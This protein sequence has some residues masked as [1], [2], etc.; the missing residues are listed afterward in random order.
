MA[1]RPHSQMLSLHD[2]AEEEVKNYDD[3]WQT[4]HRLRYISVK[5]AITLG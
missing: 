1:Q 3:E 5:Q 2:T 4:W